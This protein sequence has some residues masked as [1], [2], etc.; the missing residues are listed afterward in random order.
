ERVLAHY[1]ITEAESTGG[2]LVLGSSDGIS[3]FNPLLSSD[4]PSGHLTSFAFDTL[5][6]IDPINSEPYP[7]LLNT[8]EIAA[9]GVT[10]T[11]RL[12]QDVTWHDGTP[13]TADDVV[14]TFEALSSAD[15][16]SA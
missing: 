4:V 2:T 10:Y 9:D 14:F 6:V 7:K 8:W 15:L 16:G 11:F 1:D 13:F 5:F 3:T 12:R